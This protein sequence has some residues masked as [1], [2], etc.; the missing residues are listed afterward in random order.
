MGH[1][2]IAARVAL[3]SQLAGEEVVELGAED[4]VSHKLSLL[5]NLGGHFGFRE[6]GDVS[7]R[8]PGRR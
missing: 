6:L 8:C 1:T 3:L 7:E 5:G 4:T 2:D